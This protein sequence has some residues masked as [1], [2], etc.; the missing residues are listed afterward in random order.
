MDLSSKE[1]IV[2]VLNRRFQVRHTSLYVLKYFDRESCRLHD[3]VPHKF[4]CVFFASLPWE[5][6]LS[7]DSRATAET[8]KGFAKRVD[9][10][11]QYYRSLEYGTAW[12]NAFHTEIREFISSG[13]NAFRN[14]MHPYSEDEL[15]NISD[16]P[17]TVF[18]IYLL[19]FLVL[20]VWSKPFLFL[21]S[22]A[23]ENMPVKIELCFRQIALQIFRSLQTKKY[24]GQKNFFIC[25]FG[26]WSVII[27]VRL[28]HEP[29]KH[30]T[31]HGVNDNRFFSDSEFEEM[32]DLGSR[33]GSRI[34]PDDSPEAA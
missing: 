21:Y 12:L 11:R 18:S 2:L 29:Y 3:C 22:T 16:L 31:F 15:S 33:D 28:A 4:A 26:S 32:W 6:L 8:K 1:E 27:F 34:E 7:S 13:W 25:N 5:R 17:P 10:C 20:K 9:Y 24:Y 19:A 30:D 14:I 23:S